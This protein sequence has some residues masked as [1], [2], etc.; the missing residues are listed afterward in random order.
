MWELNRKQCM[1]SH[2]KCNQTAVGILYVCLTLKATFVPAFT[3]Y[4]T[5]GDSHVE[6]TTTSLLLFNFMN[7]IGYLPQM[8]CNLSVWYQ[9]PLSLACCGDI[10]MRHLWTLCCSCSHYPRLLLENLKSLD[11]AAAATPLTQSGQEDML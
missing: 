4:K 9:Q 1:L 3:Q 8:A 7:I 11:W 10:L 6:L 5:I 2:F